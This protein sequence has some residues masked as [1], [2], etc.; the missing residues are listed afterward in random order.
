MKL[1]KTS[2]SGHSRRIVTGKKEVL[3]NNAITIPVTHIFSSPENHNN[4]YSLLKH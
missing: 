4:Y 2:V 3:T 1:P